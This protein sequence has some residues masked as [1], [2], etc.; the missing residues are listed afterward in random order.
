MAASTFLDALKVE[1]AAL[2]AQFPNLNAWCEI[3]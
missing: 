3:L 2:Q 1:V